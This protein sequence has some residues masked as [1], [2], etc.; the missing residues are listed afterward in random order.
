MTTVTIAHFKSHLSELLGR[1]S[2]KKEPILITRHG[3]AVARILPPE[4]TSQ[5]LS[6]VRGWMDDKDPFFK[7]LSDIVK[8]RV[9]HVPRVFK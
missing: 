6:R 3:R 8:T 5:H 1:V 2:F 4:E 7:H 9:K